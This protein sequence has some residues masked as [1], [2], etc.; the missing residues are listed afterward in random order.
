M[1]FSHDRSS[2]R[3]SRS[4]MLLKIGVFRNFTVFT[5]KHLCWSLFGDFQAYK[6]IKKRLQHR[7]FPVNIAKFLRTAFFI[8]HLWWLQKQPPEVFYKRTFK[9]FF[10]AYNFIKKR[11]QHR[12]SPVNIAKFLRA[13]ISTNICEKLSVYKFCQTFLSDG[14]FGRIFSGF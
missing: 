5:W 11:R 3:N 7:C 9:I 13:P 12:C 14:A 2:H 1:V 6:F 8:E 10:Q 4:Q